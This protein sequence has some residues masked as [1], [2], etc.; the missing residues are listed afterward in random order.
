MTQNRQVLLVSRPQGPV[1]EQNFRIVD[2]PLRAPADGEV[3]VRNEWLSL[4]PY[5]RGRMSDC[6]GQGLGS[7][8]GHL[9]AMI[10][11]GT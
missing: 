6:Q 3:L 2:A 10:G 7:T 5:M 11:P 8:I 4:D 1:A 9:F